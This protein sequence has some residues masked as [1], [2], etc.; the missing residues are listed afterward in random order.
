MYYTTLYLY[1]F[2]KCLELAITMM[3]TAL[4]CSS[5]IWLVEKI[6]EQNE[7]IDRDR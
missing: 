1:Y 3:M 5:G 7:I 2:V 4:I 6:R